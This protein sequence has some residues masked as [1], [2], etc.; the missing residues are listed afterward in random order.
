MNYDNSSKYSPL[1]I[2]EKVNRYFLG[3]MR[4]SKIENLR[5]IKP[6]I[7]VLYQTKM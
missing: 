5:F 7:S 3:Q 6:F 1:R 2:K 4:Y